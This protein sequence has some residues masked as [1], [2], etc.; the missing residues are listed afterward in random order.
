MR[1]SPPTLQSLSTRVGHEDHAAFRRLYE[2]LAPATLAGIREHLPDPV[3]S[4]HVL[5][6]TFCEIW[7]MC[8]FDARCRTPQCDVP[9]WVDAVAAQRRVERVRMLDLIAAEPPHSRSTSVLAGL[10]DDLDMWT[11]FQLAATLD[12]QDAIDVGVSRHD[13]SGHV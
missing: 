6:G 8:A 9:R 7:W 12:G 2:L 5:R 1:I 11:Q 10:M 13:A 4:M 3:Q